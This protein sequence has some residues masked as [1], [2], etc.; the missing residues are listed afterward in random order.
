[1]TDGCGMDLYFRDPGMLALPCQTHDS[2]GHHYVTY[3]DKVVGRNKTMVVF[4]RASVERVVACMIMDEDVP[5]GWRKHHLA[6]DGSPDWTPL[7][8]VNGQ[9][10]ARIL[11]IGGAI[12]QSLWLEEALDTAY[13]MGAESERDRLVSLLD[14]ACKIEIK[15]V[16]G[17]YPAGTGAE[18]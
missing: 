13:K 18:L 5:E 7:L 16:P 6:N 2:S 9:N 11:R 15:N 4:R 10:A 3:A 12:I 8:N 17:V 14:T 1:M